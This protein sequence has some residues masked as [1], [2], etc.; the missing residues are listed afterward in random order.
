MNYLAY[1]LFG[2]WPGKMVLLLFITGIALLLTPTL[3]QPIHGYKMRKL[4]SVFIIICAIV[5][6]VLLLIKGIV[7][8]TSAD[9]E[10]LAAEIARTPNGKVVFEKYAKPWNELTKIDYLVLE[11]LLKRKRH[12]HFRHVKGKE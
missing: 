12:P 2:P 1:L 4:I 3:T 6:S 5:L 9:K 8:I 10:K 7:P 11:Q